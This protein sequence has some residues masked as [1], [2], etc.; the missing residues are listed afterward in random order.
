MQEQVIAVSLLVVESILL[1]TT[2]ILLLLTKREWKMREKALKSLQD[3]IRVLTR[4]Q[5]FSTVM[6]ALRSAK[7]GG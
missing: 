5:Y 7:K 4:Q 2:I 3:T 1:I 6:E